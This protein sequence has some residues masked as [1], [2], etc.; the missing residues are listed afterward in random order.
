MCACLQDTRRLL[1]S[2]TAA[3]S[4][5]LKRR[6]SAARLESDKHS[7]AEV[8]CCPVKPAWSNSGA[9]IPAAV[10]LERKQVVH[11]DAAQHYIS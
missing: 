7:A 3:V 2:E 11:A 8:R 1:Q 5:E 9:F 10:P 4:A 6:E